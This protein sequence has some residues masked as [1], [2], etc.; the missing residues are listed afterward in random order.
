MVATGVLTINLALS[1]V[2]G[3]SI[4][5]VFIAAFAGGSSVGLMAVVNIVLRSDFRWPLLVLAALWAAS[6]T[7]AAFGA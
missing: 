6:V 4:T 2:R 1:E 5:A 7:L 3:G